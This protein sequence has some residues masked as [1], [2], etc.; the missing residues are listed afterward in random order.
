MRM[1]HEF[2]AARAAAQHCAE[3]TGH[4]AARGLRPE[5][6]AAII[7][8]W[9]RDLALVLADDLSPLLSGDRLD[10]TIAEPEPLSGAD[11]LRRIGGRGRRNRPAQL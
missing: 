7:A 11:A 2:V 9:R 10:V 8:A 4:G 1:A 3:L 6:R 5:D